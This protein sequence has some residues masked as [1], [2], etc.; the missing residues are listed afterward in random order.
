M[1]GTQSNFVSTYLPY[2]QNV[3]QQTGLPV[4]YVLSQSAL[5]TGWGSSN[6]ALSGN[7]FFGISN[8]AGGNAVY[9]DVSSGFQAF[10]N[11]I[12]SPRYSNVSGTVGN[13]PVAI[14]NALVSAGYNTADPNYAGQIASIVPTID[15]VLSA[16]GYSQLATGGAGS[17]DSGGGAAGAGQ[18][19][20]GGSSGSRLLGWLGTSATSVG[21]AVVAVAFI[22]G[23]I[24]LFGRRVTNA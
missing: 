9:Q 21:L 22:L 14:G 6:A 23:G 3:S 15:S 17:A 11:L 7:N 24:Y 13:G 5:E 16:Q 8:G 2:A 4:D 12:N 10:A 20:T 19:V 1:T 18:P